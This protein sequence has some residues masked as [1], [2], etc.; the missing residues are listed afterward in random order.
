MMR[1]QKL[2][3]KLWCM[4]FLNI[5]LPLL[6]WRRVLKVYLISETSLLREKMRKIVFSQL[7]LRLM[8]IPNRLELKPRVKISSNQSLKWQDAKSKLKANSLSLVKKLQLARE[9][10]I[11]ILRVLANKKLQMHIK[12]WKDLL[13]KPQSIILQL[14]NKIYSFQVSSPNIE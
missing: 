6:L 8:I 3:K 13:K 4:F 2:Q 11:Y 1:R 10:F 12:K 5:D 9:N 7:N 14:V